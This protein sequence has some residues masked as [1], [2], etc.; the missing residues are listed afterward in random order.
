[1]I[2]FKGG[3]ELS[4]LAIPITIADVAIEIL[5]L[6]SCCQKLFIFFFWD[7]EIFVVA[8]RPEDDLQRGEWLRIRRPA[9]ASS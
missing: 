7:V 3:R 2:R 5:A 6:G 8:P 4:Y 9:M 1:V